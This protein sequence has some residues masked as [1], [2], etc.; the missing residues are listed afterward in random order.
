MKRANNGDTVSVHYTGKLADGS[1]FDSTEGEDPMVFTVGDVDFID[2]FIEAILD[3]TVGERKTVTLEP[4]QA[5]GERDEEMVIEIPRS[6]IPADLELEI[7]DELEITDEDGEPMLVTVCDLSPEII[8]LDGNPPLAGETL[9]F[10]LE[11]VAI[12]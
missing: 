10:D 1:I 9:T 7:G 11:L 5:Y 12:D 3:M 2:G 6:E 4:E 8:S